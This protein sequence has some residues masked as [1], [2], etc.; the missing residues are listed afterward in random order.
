MK[1]AIE[2][3]KTRLMSRIFLWTTPALHQARQL[4]EKFGFVLVSEVPHEDWG[5]AVV[6]QKFELM[7][8]PTESG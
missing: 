5:N 6:H 7:L 1:E 8:R 2:F 4:Y 3:C